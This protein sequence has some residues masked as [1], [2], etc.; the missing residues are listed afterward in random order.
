MAKQ[1]Q[2]DSEVSWLATSDK[3]CSV[4]YDK[5]CAFALRLQAR[6]LLSSLVFIH[7]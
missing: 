4:S 1:A 2:P 3:S 7:V 5:N 6:M